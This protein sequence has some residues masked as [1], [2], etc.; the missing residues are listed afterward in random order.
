LSN[1]VLQGHD[2]DTVAAICGGLL[3]ARLGTGWIPRERLRDRSRL[4]A[5]A[6]VLVHRKGP[7]EDCATFMQHE[8][9]WTRQEADYQK[10]MDSRAHRL[11][12]RG[13]T[14]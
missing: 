2:T 8:A 14:E 11:S 4:E 1:I 7:P 9:D 6:D 13:A 10:C 12:P 3:G 5:Y